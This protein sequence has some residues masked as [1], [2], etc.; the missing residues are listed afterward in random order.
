M[1]WFNAPHVVSALPAVF[2]VAVLYWIIYFAS[3][4]L[5]FFLAPSYF[6][7]LEAKHHVEA[8]IRIP[9]WVNCAVVVSASLYE[10]FLNPV[11]TQNRVFGSTFASRSLMIAAAGYFF[12]DLTFC[13]YKWQG[14]GFTFHA[15]VCVT[16]YTLALLPFVQFYGCVFLLFEI[17]TIFL[18][19]AWYAR[20]VF[21]VPASSLVA[22]AINIFFAFSFFVVR[23]VFGNYQSYRFYQDM[24]VLPSWMW[25]HYLF[26]FVNVSLQSLNHYWLY[27]II[28]MI[29]KGDD[30]KKEGSGADK[31]TKKSNKE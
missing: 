30:K 29:T 17:S 26:M 31:T 19:A 27:R 8:Y 22:N 11:L 16:V 4:P 13:A 15:I 24:W 3:K 28:L 21:K 1:Q 9:S 23:I 5:C 7:S 10:L 6:R 18:N 25:L 20:Y 12:F 2:I 14:P